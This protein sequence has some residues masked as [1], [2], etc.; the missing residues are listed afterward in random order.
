MIAG[1]IHLYFRNGSTLEVQ[2]SSKKNEKQQD[3]IYSTITDL[4]LRTYIKNV[5]KMLS[6]NN[7]II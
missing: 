2:Q 1:V 7:E 4:N 6:H 3:P 5:F